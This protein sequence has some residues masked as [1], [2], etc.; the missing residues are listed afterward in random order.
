MKSLKQFH[1]FN[2]TGLD[3]F[4]INFS[5]AAGDFAAAAAFLSDKL[6]ITEISFSLEISCV[7]QMSNWLLK[8]QRHC[9]CTFYDMQ[10][11]HSRTVW[12]DNLTIVSWPIAFQFSSSKWVVKSKGQ[13][14]EVFDVQFSWRDCSGFNKNQLF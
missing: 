12:Y 10:L 5:L 8:M 1:T 7:F 14:S 11:C 9:W 2:T 3:N 6:Q 13:R 4:Y